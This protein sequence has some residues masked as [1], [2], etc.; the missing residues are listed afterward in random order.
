MSI[1]TVLSILDANQFND[2]LKG[3]VDFCQSRD[4]HLTALVIAMCAAHPFSSYESLSGRLDRRQREIEAL[5]EKGCDIRTLIKGNV[6]SYDVQEIYTEYAWVDEDIAERARYADL[7]LVGAQAAQNEELRRRVVDGALFQSPTPVLIN[8]SNKRLADIP[9]VV[10]L[11]WDSSEASARA[12]RQSIDFLQ[13]AGTVH[14]TLVDPLASRALG[15]DDRGTNIATFLGRHGVR[16]AVDCVSGSG[17]TVEETLR[18]HAL[19]VGAEMIVMGAYSHPRLEQRLF[20]GVTQ[21]MLKDLLLPLF[22]AH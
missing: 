3:A 5:T 4:A 17:R 6:A 1:K 2:D 16:V 13:A 9:M 21:S 19:D 15:E 14:V 20:G 22:L 7:V 10:L 8:P 12:A 11:A 18:K